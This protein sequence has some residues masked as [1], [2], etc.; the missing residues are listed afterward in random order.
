MIQK[1]LRVLYF[2]IA[3]R[4]PKSGFLIGFSAV[5]QQRLNR[6]KQ[7]GVYRTAMPAAMVVAARQSWAH[8]SL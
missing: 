2:D 5:F 7:T 6:E 4:L 1:K 8:N 3:L